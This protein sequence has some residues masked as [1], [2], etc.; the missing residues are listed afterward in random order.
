LSLTQHDCKKYNRVSNW[1]QVVATISDCRH[2]EGAL[3]TEESWSSLDT[4]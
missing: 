1:A 3:A 4:C 2:S